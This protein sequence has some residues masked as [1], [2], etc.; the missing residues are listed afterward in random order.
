VVPM[1]LYKHVANKKDLLDGMVD[2]VIGLAAA[3]QGATVKGWVSK[4]RDPRTGAI[5]PSNS[6]APADRRRPAWQ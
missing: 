6:P 1:A 3:S 4:E 2:I 5:G